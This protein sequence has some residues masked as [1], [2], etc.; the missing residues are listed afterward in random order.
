MAALPAPAR[1]YGPASAATV[2]KI[3]N[4]FKPGKAGPYQLFCLRSAV[5][6]IG[7]SLGAGGFI[8]SRMAENRFIEAAGEFCTSYP[9]GCSRRQA[10][11]GRRAAG[12]PLTGGL[13]RRAD[14]RRPP[15]A[16]TDHVPWKISQMAAAT[17]SAKSKPSAESPNVGTQ[18]ES[19]ACAM[20]GS[21]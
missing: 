7:R 16:V 15:A 9:A 19:V 17:T 21:M 5:N 12:D 2:G 10:D 20:P 1:R 18:S 8:S 6:P 14:N 3:R 11:H 13:R 4:Y